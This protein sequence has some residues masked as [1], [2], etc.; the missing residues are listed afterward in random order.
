[1]WKVMIV[2]DE[3][4][5]CKL[6]QALVEW[7]KLGMQMAAQAENAIQAL[8]MLQQYRPDILIT[9][10]RMPGMDGLEL[11]KNAKKICPELEIIIISGYAHFEYARNALSLGVGNYLLKPIKQDELNET[12]R[13]IGERLDAKKSAQGMEM[14]E[15]RVSESDVNRLRY[16]LLKDLVEDAYNPTAVQLQENYYFKA[17]ADCYQ[18][19]VVKAGYDPEQMSKAAQTVICEKTKEL[20]YHCLS[21]NCND[22]LFDYVKDSGYGILNFIKEIRIK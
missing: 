13:K 6:V 7:D 8:D 3:K 19:I 9:D 4:L 15:R 5:I 21:K 18:A 1:M 17:E 10:I 2:D 12:L 20:F 14:A 16:A 11:I 22:C